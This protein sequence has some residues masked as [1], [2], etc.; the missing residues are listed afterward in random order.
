MYECDPAVL[1]DEGAVRGCMID[2]ARLAG[3]TIVSECF[4][5]F[6]PHGISGVLVIAE[7]HLA[8]HT[9]PEHGY[10]AVDLFTCSQTLRPDACFAHLREAFRSKRHT[11]STIA[12][13]YPVRDP[14]E[15]AK[16]P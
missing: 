2:A 8:I 1:D 5:R 12:R 7:S 14:C 3:A 4:H 10:A 9:W 13:G 11:T 6:S 15:R 16:G